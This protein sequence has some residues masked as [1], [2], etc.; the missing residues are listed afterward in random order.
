MCIYV[1]DIGFRIFYVSI[2]FIDLK[3]ITVKK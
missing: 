2:A 1:A 3:K